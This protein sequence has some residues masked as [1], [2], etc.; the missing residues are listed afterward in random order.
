MLTTM[1]TM[2]TNILMA[3]LCNEH[4]HAVH[5]FI[6]FI[7]QSKTTGIPFGLAMTRH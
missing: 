1:I 5:S 4:W 3:V 6:P 2:K 7:C